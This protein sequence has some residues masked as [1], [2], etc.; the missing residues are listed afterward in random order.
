MQYAGQTI[1]KN[2]LV[3][4]KP[5]GGAGTQRLSKPDNSFP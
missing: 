2:I 3:R 1:Y 5:I 4:S